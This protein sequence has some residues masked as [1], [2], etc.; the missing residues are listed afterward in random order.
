MLQARTL[1]LLSISLSVRL[2]FSSNVF[3][4]SSFSHLDDPHIGYSDMEDE[5]HKRCLTSNERV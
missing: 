5:F 1:A 4:F 3:L 2:A